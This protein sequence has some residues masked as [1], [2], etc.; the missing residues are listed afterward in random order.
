MTILKLLGK[1]K[2]KSLE[3]ENEYEDPKLTRIDPKTNFVIHNRSKK[4]FYIFRKGCENEV[5]TQLLA[6]KQ[7]TE[8]SHLRKNRYGDLLIMQ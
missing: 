6:K 5:I 4:I 1:E 8:I 7:V 3:N 2:V